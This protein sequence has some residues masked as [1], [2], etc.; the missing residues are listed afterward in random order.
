ML[1]SCDQVL[2]NSP[3]G[4]DLQISA[5]SGFGC[6]A[7]IDPRGYFLTAGHCLANKETYLLV[8]SSNKVRAVRARVVWRGKTR[9]NQPDLGILRVPF[10]LKSTFAW[11]P[12]VNTDEPVIAV[13][14]AWTIQPNRELRGLA[15]LAG[16][17]LG[18]QESKQELGTSSVEHDIPLQ[19]GDS[20]GPLVDLNGRLLGVN[21]RATPPLI[22]KVLS[23]RLVPTVAQRADWA[24]LSQFIEK[25]FASHSM[26]PDQ[27]TAT[28]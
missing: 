28:R 17:I 12:E 14:L 16:R 24:Y 9:L 18:H 15:F 11:A 25:D 20:G 7:A 1:I 26:P 10:E 8:Y 22:R 27:C 2:T 4:A 5:E 13:G 21:I 19:S 3:K 6:A 23:D